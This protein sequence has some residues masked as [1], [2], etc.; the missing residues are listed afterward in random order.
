MG[1]RLEEEMEGGTKGGLACVVC[2]DQGRFV[3]FS[4][5]FLSE[6]LSGWSV[7]NGWGCLL[8]QLL[9]DA[10]NRRGEVGGEGVGLCPSTLHRCSSR[11][12]P[13]PGLLLP[14]DSALAFRMPTTRRRQ[15]KVGIPGTSW[16]LLI[17][18]PR[19][20]LALVIIANIISW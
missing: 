7:G 3:V 6:Y 2:L 11:P 19:L 20:A 16:G 18:F 8:C 17:R 4:L 5:L 12:S 14:R 9:C 1:P 13:E 10:W 15:A